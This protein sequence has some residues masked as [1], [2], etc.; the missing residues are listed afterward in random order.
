MSNFI[1]LLT[2]SVRINPTLAAENERHARGVLAPYRIQGGDIGIPRANIFL[3]PLQIS[4]AEDTYKIRQLS[5]V[6]VQM[7]LQSMK[8]KGIKWEKVPIVVAF[9][10]RNPSAH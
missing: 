3:N 4:L 2:T 10:G 6:G 1:E 8:T 9:G 7:I 5:D